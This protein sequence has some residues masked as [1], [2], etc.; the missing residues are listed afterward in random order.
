MTNFSSIRDAGRAAAYDFI[1]AK[2]KWP[3]AHEPKNPFETASSE[4]FNAWQEAF[5]QTYEKWKNHD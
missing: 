1:I 4:K 3:L 2:K 5:T